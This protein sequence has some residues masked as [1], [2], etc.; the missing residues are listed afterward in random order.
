[1]VGPLKT[2]SFSFDVMIDVI[3]VMGI[4]MQNH[5]FNALENA[6]LIFKLSRLFVRI[7]RIHI[8][9]VITKYLY[10]FLPVID[11]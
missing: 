3:I 10:C 4:R 2:A 11:N 5:K 1:M 9:M 8:T 6:V 7:I